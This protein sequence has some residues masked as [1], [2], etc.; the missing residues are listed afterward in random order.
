M[1][2][3]DGLLEAADARGEQFGSTR[4]LSATANTAPGMR[5]SAVEQ[6]LAEHLGKQSATDDVSLMLIDCP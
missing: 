1:L 2:Y 6:A 3:S 5:F 4:L